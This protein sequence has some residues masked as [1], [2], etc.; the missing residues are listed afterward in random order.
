MTTDYVLEYFLLFMHVM[1]HV[2][3]ISL[4]DIPLS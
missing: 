3:S 4:L 2:A 1:V